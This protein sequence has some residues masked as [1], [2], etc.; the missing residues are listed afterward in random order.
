[1]DEQQHQQRLLELDSEG[2]RELFKAAG[3]YH[4][5]HSKGPGG[6]AICICGA[7]CGGSKACRGLSVIRTMLRYA[8]WGD[9]AWEERYEQLA[10]WFDR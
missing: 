3:E 7:A 6:A 8:K 1:M 2:I 4:N 5:T 10:Q 9:P